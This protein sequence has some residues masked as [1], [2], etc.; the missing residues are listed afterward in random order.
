[1]ELL[2]WTGITCQE[3]IRLYIYVSVFMA[4]LKGT[5]TVLHKYYVCSWCLFA[6]LV[7]VLLRNWGNT[8][9]G[10]WVLW[11][12]FTVARANTEPFPQ[13]CPELNMTADFTAQYQTDLTF[14]AGPF[15]SL[16]QIQ[17]SPKTQ[18]RTVKAAEFILTE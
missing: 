5:D 10:E 1:M 11:K 14:L 8:V 16:F 2:C 13:T 15:K 4:Y 17:W 12:C 9:W 18:N 7:P 3:V 6:T